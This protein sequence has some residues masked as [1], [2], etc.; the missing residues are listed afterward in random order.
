M[1]ILSSYSY[2][3]VFQCVPSLWRNPQPERLRSGFPLVII[4][5]LCRENWNCEKNWS[6]NH[7]NHLLND[8][9]RWTVESNRV[10]RS[11]SWTLAILPY[12]KV[13][14]TSYQCHFVHNNALTL[15]KC[16]L[17]IMLE[18]TTEIMNLWEIFN[19]FDE[20]KVRV[21]HVS[22]IRKRGN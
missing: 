2:G 4:S 9:W 17:S 8:F 11:L 18:P 20:S 7:N 16:S 3:L 15:F 14:Q 6:I 10:L 12:Y 13:H 21:L 22:W 5:L 19:K 1:V